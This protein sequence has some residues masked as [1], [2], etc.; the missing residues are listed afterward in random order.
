MAGN[1]W[2]GDFETLARQYW[3]AWGDLARQA[4]SGASAAQT[5]GLPQWKQ[6]V[7]WWTQLAHGG[8]EEADAAVERFNRAAH[9]WFGAMQQVATRFAGTDA[10]AA[11]IAQGWKQALGAVGENPFPEMFRS[12]RDHGQQGL[13]QW[14]EDASPYLNAW[15]NESLGWLRQPAFGYAREHQ[16]RWQKLAQAQL[17]YQQQTSAYSALMAKAGQRA[18]E[19]FERLLAERSEPGR[20]LTSARAL[21]DL[22]ID[23]AEEGYAEIALSPEFRQVYGDLVNAQMRL[24]AGVQAEIEQISGSFGV[25]T[26]SEVDASHRKLAELQRELRALKRQL[27]DNGATPPAR[28]PTNALP[29]PRGRAG[30]GARREAAPRA[31][32]RHASAEATSKPAAKRVAKFAKKGK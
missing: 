14:V 22:W 8:R 12:M 32:S 3:S 5:P 29:R 26:R 30:E 21:F 1:P 2:G 31:P 6:A 10:G 16:E 9:G 4:G 11:D 28:T 17:D 19:H 15:R 13:D 25:P 27:A 23:A 7:D 24:R 18:F 20:Q